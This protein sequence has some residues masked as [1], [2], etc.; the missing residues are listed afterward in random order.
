MAKRLRETKP[1]KK[2]LR[3]K[4]KSFKDYLFLLFFW[5][6]IIVSATYTVFAV[7]GYTM[8][9]ETKNIASFDKSRVRVGVFNGCRNTRIT[10]DIVDLLRKRGDVDVVDIAKSPTYTFPKTL[11]VERTNE[12]VKTKKLADALCIS[13]DCR[14]KQFSTVSMLR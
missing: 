1:A 3:K 9:K 5:S 14:I 7:I 6:L 8:P 13:K 12:G 11:I 2:L 10:L 4:E